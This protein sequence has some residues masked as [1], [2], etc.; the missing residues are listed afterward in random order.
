MVAGLNHQ[1]L[2]LPRHNDILF[3]HVI[4]SHNMWSCHI[5][6]VCLDVAIKMRLSGLIGKLRE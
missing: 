6:H 1:Q 4:V 5:C 3:L 2:L